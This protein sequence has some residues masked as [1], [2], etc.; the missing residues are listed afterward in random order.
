[1]HSAL[2][3]SSPL[4]TAFY[5]PCSCCQDTSGLLPSLLPAVSSQE[6]TQFL[7]HA[8]AALQACRL[9]KARSRTRD[10]ALVEMEQL[11]E[12]LDKH[13]AELPPPV[14]LR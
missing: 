5:T 2:P 13:C 6:R 7:L 8:A 1:M 10:R 3:C 4:L 11:V 12:S 14:R 9:E